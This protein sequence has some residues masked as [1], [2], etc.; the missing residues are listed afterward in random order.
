[1]AF[2]TSFNVPSYKLNF[3]LLSWDL[4]ELTGPDFVE[5]KTLKDF[6]KRSK[7]A[8]GTYLPFCVMTPKNTQSERSERNVDV[9]DNVDEEAQEDQFTEFDVVEEDEVEDDNSA[10]AADVMLRNSGSIEGDFE[11][12]IGQFNDNYD[13]DSV[14]LNSIAHQRQ[15]SKSKS[16][17][18]HF[19]LWLNLLRLDRWVFSFSPYFS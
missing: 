14:L 12:E 9:E 15:P 8:Y 4:F 13:Y 2:A 6:H 10:T 17:I 3:G 5:D 7:V 11:E 18:E 1:M 19:G 16:N